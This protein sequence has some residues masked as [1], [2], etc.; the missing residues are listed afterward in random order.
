MFRRQSLHE[1]FVA[2]TKN[3]SF[4][5]VLFSVLLLISMKRC[6]WGNTLGSLCLPYRRWAIVWT[7][8]S[9]VLC[10][11]YNMTVIPY[12]MSV[13][14]LLLDF[15]LKAYNAGSVWRKNYREKRVTCNTNL[16]KCCLHCSVL[17]SSGWILFI[18]NHLYML[19]RDKGNGE[20][21]L[22]NPAYREDQLCFNKI[23]KIL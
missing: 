13:V 21:L 15:H 7:V 5:S 8:S 9:R 19:Y 1:R 22:Y 20:R 12:L 23:A 2:Q 10:G 18:S 17:H 11:L 16:M 6:Y 3:C 14:I 4:S